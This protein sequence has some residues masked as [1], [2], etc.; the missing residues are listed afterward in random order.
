MFLKTICTNVA[1]VFCAPDNGGVVY[2]V[3]MVRGGIAKYEALSYE[4]VATLA[5]RLFVR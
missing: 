1:N 5:H 2:Y 4:Y 3:S